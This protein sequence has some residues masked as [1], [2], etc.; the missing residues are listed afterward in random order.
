MKIYIGADHRGFELKN[1]LVEFLKN[2]NFEVEDCGAEF[3]DHNDDY[4]DYAVTVCK[5]VFKK[6][7]EDPNSSVGILLCGSGMGMCIVANKFK[8]IR[9]TNVWSTEFAKL[10][11]SHDYSNVLCLPA[12]ILNEQNVIE[13]FE[14]WFKEKYNKD[15]RYSRRIE[16]IQKLEN[17]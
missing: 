2:N 4:V 9:A 15:E 12:D 1:K 10:S 14:I 11:K 7:L 17:L 13:I 5:K 8:G 16:K 6:N 3:F